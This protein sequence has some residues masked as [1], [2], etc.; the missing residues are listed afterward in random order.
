MLSDKSLDVG[1]TVSWVFKKICKYHYDR[2]QALSNSNPTLLAEFLQT[3]I[4]CLNSN[5]KLII[6]ICE[7]FYYYSALGAEKQGSVG[8]YRTNILLAYYELLFNN[9]MNIA[10]LKDSISP[11]YNIPLYAF[12]AISALIEN[13]PADVLLFIQGFL[14]HFVNC[15]IETRQKEKFE[16]VE[17][18]CLYQEYLCSVI[19]SYLCDHKITLTLD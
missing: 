2:I 17:H 16:S 9:L 10:Y 13:A 15:L 4:K 5:K 1:T 18:R 11:E 19:S 7:S 3:L 14:T 6:D 12:Y 8:Q